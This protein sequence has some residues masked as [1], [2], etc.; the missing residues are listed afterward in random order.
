MFGLRRF[1]I[2][3]GLDTISGILDGMGDPHKK[4]SSVHVAG[5]NGKGSIASYISRILRESGCRV[6]L[7]TSPHLVKFNERIRIDG[8]PITDA[9]VLEAYD[10][11]KEV[12]PGDREP[13][14]FEYTTAMAF[15]EFA[16]RKVDWAVVETG[17]GGR[18]D[19]TNVLSPVV[20]V[21]SNISIEHRSYLGDTLAEI[22]GEKGGII[23]PGTP[24][25]TGASQKA[26]LDVFQKI[27][28]G[29]SAELF[30][31]GRHFRVRKNKDDGAF[32]YFGIDSNWPDLKTNLS[33]EHQLENSSVALAACEML[34][35][36][37]AKIEFAHVRKGMAGT[38]WPGR[39]EI[40][41]ESPFVILDGA[42]NLMA[43]RNLARYISG[44][45][46][47]KNV[48]MVLG[49]LDDKPYKSML[50]SLL[51]VCKRAILTRP[52]INRA[53][54][55]E[56]LAEFARDLVSEVKIVPNVRDAVSYAMDTAGKDEAICV[57]G[58]LYVVQ[59]KRGSYS[60]IRSSLA[61]A[62]FGVFGPATGRFWA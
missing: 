58:S 9:Q 49:I 13:T 20:S 36:K 59:G 41:S 33:G 17:M 47:E 24:V 39:L 37:G 50:K 1:G 29:N 21:I 12:H 56:V 42:H 51:P 38:Q 27:A 15:H 19:A 3:L 8:E 2:K 35:R 18:L 23:K 22:A 14:F 46:P 25:V 10:A 62:C 11:V 34:I 45:F 48:T 43:A 54:E 32:S 57:A 5:T 30:R 53:L 55:P 26:C 16:R 44:R 6:G 52:V 31:L 61:D 28:A 40:V 4:F 7:Y 60:L